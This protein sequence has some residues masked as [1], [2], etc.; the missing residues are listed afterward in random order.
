MKLSVCVITYNHENYIERCLKSIVDQ[1]V[2]FQ[3]EIIVG[4]DCSTD[5]TR[6][7]IRGMSEKYPGIIVPIFHEKNVGVYENYISVHNKAKGKYI[8]HLDGDDCMLPSKLQKCVDLLDS[9]PDVGVVFHRMML[10]YGEG[11]KRLD[12]I[13]TD[14][15]GKQD[16]E[17][18]DLL[19]IGSIACHSSRMYRESLRLNKYPEKFLD[20]Y[21]DVQQLQDMKAHI[22]NEHLGVYSVGVG[23]ASTGKTQKIYIEHLLSFINEFPDF[24]GYIGANITTVLLSDLKN[25]RQSSVKLSQILECGILKSVV[26]FF[27]YL[28]YRKYIRIP[29]FR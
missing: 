8:C 25:R 28:R 15:M 24:K 18:K 1:V 5:N 26:N 10:D 11:E 14:L 23:Q 22:I 4:E 29:R 6:N 12:T 20:F 16:F 17:Q 19:A 21:I 7:V 13:D 27:K 3:F 9:R 2:N